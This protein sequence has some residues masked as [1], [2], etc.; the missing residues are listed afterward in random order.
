[1]PHHLTT[2]QV[3]FIVM[4]DSAMSRSI[5]LVNS[6]RKGK[7]DPTR[8]LYGRSLSLPRMDFTWLDAVKVAREPSCPKCG[9]KSNTGANSSVDQVT[10]S[11]R[12][13]QEGLS[14]AYLL[15]LI[16]NFIQRAGEL[17]RERLAPAHRRMLMVDGVVSVALSIW[18]SYQVD[19]RRGW[20]AIPHSRERKSFIPVFIGK[21]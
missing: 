17:L 3:A 5:I 18:R 2:D 8:Q 4:H 6:G 9:S 15:F 14:A 20:I 10:A 21:R 13:H 1:M 12:D 19:S 16:T 7:R 11:F